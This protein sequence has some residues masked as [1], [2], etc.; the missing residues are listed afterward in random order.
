MGENISEYIEVADTVADPPLKSRFGAG[1]ATLSFLAL[2]LAQIVTGIAVV[3]VAMAM[4]L[5]RGE[6]I[7]DP[8]LVERVSSSA[9]PALLILSGVVSALAA[10]ALARLWAWPLVRDTSEAGLGLTSARRH[11]IVFSA[12]AGVVIGALFLSVV[13]WV[14]P[15]DPGTPAGPLATA[16][17]GGWPNRMAFA[18]LALLFAPVVEEFFFRGLLL[19][20]FTSSWGPRVGAVVVTALFVLSHLTETFRYWPATVAVTVVGIGTVLARTASRSL[21]PAVAL[22][23]SYNLVIVVSVLTM[24]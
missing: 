19:K 10:L 14:V 7:G 1:K 5:L 3:F 6:K 13:T 23:A 16:A 11:H 2:L 24:P 15:Q 4:A 21:G 8:T 20:G 18:V 17:M 12:G 22:H 9:T